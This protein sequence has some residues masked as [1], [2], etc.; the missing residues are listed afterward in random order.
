M[1]KGKMEMCKKRPWKKGL[2]PLVTIFLAKPVER[3]QEG[4]GALLDNSSP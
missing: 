3:V 4:H 2:V 1:L